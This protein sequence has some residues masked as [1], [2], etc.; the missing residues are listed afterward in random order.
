MFKASNKYQSGCLSF[1]CWSS[2]RVSCLNSEAKVV[3][4]S[5]SWNTW[6]QAWTCSTHFHRSSQINR[7]TSV[8][9]CSS[10]A[11]GGEEE[12]VR[13]RG[14][15]TSMKTPGM[16]VFNQHNVGDFYDIGENLGRWVLILPC[17]AEDVWIRAWFISVPPSS[18]TAPVRV[19]R[20]ANDLF[21]PD[22]GRVTVS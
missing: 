6:Q 9:V 8:C 12:V 3:Q 20:Y 1:P 13:I 14:P 11:C 22:T 2:F 4:L 18:E 19:H 17:A 21:Q 7:N 10:Y 16:A 5:P 15:S